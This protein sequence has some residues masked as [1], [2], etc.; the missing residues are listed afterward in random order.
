MSG[1]YT[2]QRLAE[3]VQTSS[4][5]ADVMRALGLKSSGGNRHALQKQAAEY[6]IDASHFKKQS[7]WRKYSDH[8]I[9]EAV[10]SSTTLREVAHKLGARPASGTLS[11][12]RRRIALA[13]I[14]VSHIPALNRK[15]TDLPFSPDELRVA[16][17]S[18]DSI[19]SAACL[20]GLPEDGSRS[21]AALR[22]MLT[23][24]D[25]DTSHFAHARLAL[26][27]PQLREAVARSSSYA[28]VMRALNLPVNF[29]NHRRLRRQIS[30]LDLD[31]CH[32]S[33]V[34][35]GSSRKVAAPRFIAHE[36]LRVLSPD[37]P[38]PKRAR[39]RRAL[40]EIG[41]PYRCSGC[42][43]GGEWLG[44]PMTLQIDHI[45]GDWLDNRRENLRYLCPNC[46]AVTGTWCGRNRT[47]SPR[48][49]AVADRPAS[50]A[51]GPDRVTVEG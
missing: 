50:L 29:V 36:V 14:D 31:T 40:D 44:N 3:V 49:S 37:S 7:P 13:G 8:A 35:W 6:G 38:R 43:N 18:A 32:F 16:T 34:P 47:G 15:P 27:E 9:A 33:R 28:D 48:A 41:V 25:I 42:G 5:W 17:E 22:R 11:H 30:R 4:T 2:A 45:N 24:H 20:L 46:H 21:R 39:L 12:I 10:A 1:Q 26:P 23:A 19:R 51:G